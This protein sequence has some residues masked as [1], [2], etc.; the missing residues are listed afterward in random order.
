MGAGLW[1]CKILSLFETGINFIYTIYE[2]I[3]KG[4]RVIL[5]QCFTKNRL[6]LSILCTIMN[7]FHGLHKNILFYLAILYNK[8]CLWVR[9]P[10]FQVSI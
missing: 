1:F 5:K 6:L 10:Y 8:I 3:C 4:F 2:Q 9:I 7:N